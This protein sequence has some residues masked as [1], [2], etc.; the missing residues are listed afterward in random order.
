MEVDGI[1]E[2]LEVTI[3]DCCC[4]GKG[5]IVFLEPK[6][7]FKSWDFEEVDYTIIT[8]AKEICKIQSCDLTLTE[9]CKQAGKTLA[10]IT[11]YEQVSY[12]TEIDWSEKNEK[13]VKAFFANPNR[14]ICKN[15]NGEDRLIKFLQTN[16]AFTIKRE[17]TGCIELL[18]TGV[19]NTE[20]VGAISAY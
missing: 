18:I 8:E 20:L 14:F 4:K 6:G 12:K 7:S 5:Q 1:D 15:I 17:E 3:K 11:Y 19:F 16:G 9:R 10:N 13:L 2:I